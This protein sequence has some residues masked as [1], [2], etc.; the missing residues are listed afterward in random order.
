MIWRQHIH[1]VVLHLADSWS[2][3]DLEM[4]VFE[5]RG[6]Q[7]Y[8]EKN[9]LEQRRKTNNKFNPHMAPALSSLRHR[10]LR[11]SN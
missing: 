8:L 3:W 2:N 4:L 9:L 11:K 1:K 6:K 10:L 7:E 5:E